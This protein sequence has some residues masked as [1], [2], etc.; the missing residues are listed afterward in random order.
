MGVGRGLRVEVEVP[1]DERTSTP[2]C[3]QGHR[4][5]S[6]PTCC[7]CVSLDRCD[8]CDLLVGLEGF[9][10]MSVARTPDALMLDIESCD[11][12]AGCPGCGVIAQGHGRVVV[13]VI[14]A[15]WAGVPARIRWHK[16]HWICREHTCET[17]TFLER[18]EKVCAPINTR[19]KPG[20]HT[21]P[22]AALSSGGNCTT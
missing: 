12:C 16:R 2:R 18:S 13:E 20:A 21:K 1:G 3:L 17:V 6:G 8:R 14:D 4:V 11:R 5:V 19:G 15:D 9:H 10:L 22:H 7:C